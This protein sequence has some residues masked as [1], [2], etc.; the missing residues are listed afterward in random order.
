MVTTQP[1]PGTDYKCNTGQEDK[2]EKK[3]VEVEGG[4]G[5]EG[6]QEVIE[7]EQRR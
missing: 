3:E 5:R 6:P 4:K 1:A 2:E 7:P